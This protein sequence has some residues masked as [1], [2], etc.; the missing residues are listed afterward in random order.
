MTAKELKSKNLVM[1]HLQDWGL[2]DDQV[3]WPAKLVS[4]SMLEAIIEFVSA[5]PDES[6]RD[7]WGRKS[8]INNITYVY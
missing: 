2:D 5:T 6:Y 3:N 4:M 7:I 8:Q 1:P